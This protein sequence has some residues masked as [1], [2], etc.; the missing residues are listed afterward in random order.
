MSLLWEFVQQIPR[1]WKFTHTLGF[2]KVMWLLDSRVCHQSRM[3]ISWNHLI[4][5]TVSSI[6]FF[7]KPIP[8]EV[9][10]A[11]ASASRF[12]VSSELLWH[13][14]CCHVHCLVAQSNQLCWVGCLGSPPR[15]VFWDDGAQSWV[16]CGGRFC[17][18]AIDIKSMVQAPASCGNVST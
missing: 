14:H 15:V 5:K 9:F 3:Q 17:W 18:T 4:G 10:I 13:C 1:S 11:I 2:K 8:T 7:P 12:C 16:W 6:P